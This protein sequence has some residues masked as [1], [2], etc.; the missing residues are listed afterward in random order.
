MTGKNARTVTQ[1]VKDME[2]LSM[3][4]YDVIGGNVAKIAALFPQCVTET[5]EK[6]IDSNGATRYESRLAIDFD[7]LREELSNEVLDEG[8]ERYQFT[9]PDKRAASRLAN[10]STTQTLRPCREESVDF[11]TTENLYIQGDNLDVLKV[12]RETYLGKVKMI[13]IDPPYNTGNDFVY[14]DDF[15]QGVDE[16]EQSSSARDENGNLITDPMQRNTES[17][18]RFHTD[19][20]NMI[21]PRIKVARDMLTKDGV[22][23]ISLDD[24]E[25]ANMMK[26]CN[27]IFG[28]QNFVGNIIWQSR[29]SISNEDEIST[30]HNHTLVYSK[31]RQSLTFG[32]DDI[33]E[34]EY[35][36]PD[37]DPRGPWKLVPIDANHVG[38]DTNYPIRN[39]KKWS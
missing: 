6:I 35:I 36:N 28:E 39:P 27:E 34:N 20:L 5:A 1:V 19:W 10:E 21:Y 31:D 30:N 7:K 12:L 25:V 16:Y 9:W 26:I 23:F 32:G 8:E 29:T 18:G 17:N 13:Y 24:N 22:I 37:N 15:A 2:R 4:S 3:Q 38:G 11:D 33:D 14:N